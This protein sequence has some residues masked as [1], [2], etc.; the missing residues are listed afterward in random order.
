MPLPARGEQE[1]RRYTDVDGDRDDDGDG[2]G[3]GA[4]PRQS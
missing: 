2:D 1:A 4:D 3:D